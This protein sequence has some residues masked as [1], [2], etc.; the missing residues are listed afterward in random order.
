MKS[1]SIGELSK[2]SG[3]KITTI[4]YYEKVGLIAEPERSSGGRRLYLESDIKRI[5][6]IKHS[7]FLGFPL[8]AIREMLHL[9][10]T[11]EMDCSTA[12][13]IAER[14]LALVKQRIS[15][16]QALEGELERIAEAC[17]GGSVAECK[18]IEAL[19]DHSQ[20]EADRHVKIEGL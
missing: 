17:G 9:Q 2:Q 6:F 7:R 16:L 15:Q 12:N 10:A 19:G 5:G 3:V 8:D 13:E 20:C 14:Q 11:P 4:R 18:V 1:L